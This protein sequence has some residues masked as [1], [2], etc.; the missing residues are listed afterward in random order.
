MLV[1][2]VQVVAPLPKKAGLGSPAVAVSSASGCAQVIGQPGGGAGSLGIAGVSMTVFASRALHAEV[3]RDRTMV[4]R[5]SLVMFMVCSLLTSVSDSGKS[6]SSA[7]L[8][9]VLLSG[10][11]PCRT[12]GP[13]DPVIILMPRQRSLAVAGKHL[14]HILIDE[15][16]DRS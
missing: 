12:G 2:V 10:H 15:N 8:T 3:S 1:D 11:R 7:K 16:A 13:E 5:I 6:T 14:D 4:F 9:F